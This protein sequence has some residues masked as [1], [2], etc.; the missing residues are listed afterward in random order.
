[1]ALPWT[2]NSTDAGSDSNP[3]LSLYM[4]DEYER[5]KPHTSSM[6]GKLA[7]D[8]YAATQATADPTVRKQGEQVL[9]EECP[10]N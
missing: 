5:S 9:K 3:G 4:C 2:S 8:R 1:M 6:Q 10:W 7:S